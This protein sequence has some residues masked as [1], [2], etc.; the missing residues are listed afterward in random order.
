M[1]SSEDI[2]AKVQRLR[3]QLAVAPIPVVSGTNITLFTLYDL[4]ELLA[5]PWYFPFVKFIPLATELANLV[6]ENYTTILLSNQNL[7]TSFENPSNCP[8]S[9]VSQPLAPSSYWYY[10][11]VDAQYANLCVDTIPLMNSTIADLR[12][13]TQTLITQSPSM[14]A[15]LS[16]LRADC[17][18]W[19]VTAKWRFPGPFQTPPP[20]NSSTS[21]GPSAPIL[22][23]ASQ[24]DPI[25]PLNNAIAMSKH[26][27]DSR[28]VA[29]RSWGHSTVF[30][31]PSNCT[32]GIIR[33]YLADGV[34]PN[35]GNDTSGV[36]WCDADCFN[37]WDDCTSYM[38]PPPSA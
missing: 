8:G 22:F 18:G 27:P 5:A 28:V 19:S 6:N 20:S 9:P 33:Q 16:D 25:T 10:P 7:I 24:F 29:Q 14:G 1:S 23:L 32:T 26:H 31:A 21:N 3:D 35:A 11:A 13:F 37:P 15:H 17:A 12:A 2:R 4:E 34:V 38:N 30:S 36:V